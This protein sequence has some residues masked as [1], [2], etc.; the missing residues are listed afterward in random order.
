[1][2]MRTLTLIAAGTLGGLLAL[3]QGPPPDNG[4]QGEGPDVPGRAARLSLVQGTVSFQPASVED[5]V[6]ATLN[7]P[8]TTG[9]RVWTEAGSRAELHLGSAAFRLN[10]RTNFSFINL[11]DRTAQVQLSVG[12]LEVR[13]R[14][15]AE[16]EV[17]E[18]DT[19]Q[20]ALSILRPGEYRVDVNEEGDATIATVRGGQMEA[21]AGQAY[22]IRPRDQVRIMGGDG[23]EATFDTRPAPVPD[24]FDNWCEDRDRREDRSESARYVSRDMPGYADLDGAGGWRQYPDYGAV[25]FPGNVPPGW[26]P[27]RFG[28]WAWIAPWG[29]T[30]VDDAPWGYAPFHYGRWV[31]VGGGWGWV[32]GPVVVGVR[33]VY[34]PALVAWVGGPR[35]GV[36]IGFG[37]GVGAVGWFPLGPREVFVPSYRYSAA[38]VER[39]NVTNTVIVNRTVFNNVNVTSVNYVNRGVPGG[40]TAVSRETMVGGRPVGGAAIRVAPGAM[41]Q[42]SVMEHPGFVPQREAVMGGRAPVNVA[43]PQAAMNRMVV[44]RTRPPAPP[45]AFQHQQA[46]LQAN[47]GR[48]LNAAGMNQVRSSAPASAQPRQMYRVAPAAS[49]QANPALNRQYQQK[50]T[51]PAQRNVNPQYQPQQPQ[52]SAPQR[53]VNPQV[54]QQPRTLERQNTPQAQPVPQAQPRSTETNTPP[55]N[56]P[57]DLKQQE[58]LKQQ[59]RPKQQERLKQERRD[60][61]KEK[62]K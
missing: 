15:L 26:A 43:P 54:Q 56:N 61:R 58:T 38:Y 35:F 48:P 18:I 60:E 27:Y 37:G 40:V 30:W 28:H 11:D 3:A 17:F 53:N 13:V 55:R 19:P 1:M 10:G 36:A 7:R 22:T 29:W 57:R 62:E 24:P 4:P 49:Q 16:D 33:P 41:Q 42:A 32:P 6:P 46:A 45:V 12:S 9:D 47:Q 8:I 59:D 14:R 39:V 2:R 44:T 5:W 34:A 23:T 51:T 50:Q 31:F 20:A 52:Q 21:T 25:W